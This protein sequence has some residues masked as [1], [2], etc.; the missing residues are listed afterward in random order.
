M[1]GPLEA[2]QPVITSLSDDEFGWWDGEAI[3]WSS[4]EE[5]YLVTYN[6]VHEATIERTAAS[7]L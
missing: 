7:Q 6:E 5:P 1:T 3:V 2:L 4:P